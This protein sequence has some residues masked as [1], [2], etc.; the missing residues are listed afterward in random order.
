MD[1]KNK[2]IKQKFDLT[3]KNFQKNLI[4]LNNLKQIA[5]KF[6]N[7]LKAK[8]L[9]LKELGLLL[10]EN[11]QMKKNFTKNI[12]NNYLDKIYRR[13]I[14]NG[15]YGG[16]LL[17]AGGGGFFIFICKKEIQK[18]IIKKVKN[19]KFVKF[20]FYSQGTKNCYID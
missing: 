13:A 9:N 19:C 11:W 4:N 10:D 6:N 1:R 2:A 20:K 3:K 12:T 15:C 14:S 8:N 16:K 7:K 5:F 18:K 17:G